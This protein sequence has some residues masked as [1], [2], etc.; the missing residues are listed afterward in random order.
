VGVARR[1]ERAVG[2]V[3]VEMDAGEGRDDVDY[4]G[5]RAGAAVGG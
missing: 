4:G 3:A 1:D 5:G 2:V